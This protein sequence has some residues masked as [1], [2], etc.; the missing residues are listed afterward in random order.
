MTVTPTWL[1][2]FIDLPADQHT[3]GV[4]FWRAVTGY[5][6]S[7]PRGDDAEYAT[8][9]PADG[10]PYLRV[11]RLVDEGPA[12]VHL[13]LHDPEQEFQVLSSPAGLPYCHVYA[14]HEGRPRPATWPGGHQSIVDTVCI[15]IPPSRFEEEC[16]FWTERTG[17]PVVEFPTAPE[18]LGLRRPPGQ[19]IRILLQRLSD[20]QPQATAHLDLS[21]NGRAAE[22]RRHRDLGAVVV[23]EHEWWTVLR[24]PVGAEYCL[25]DRE[26]A[27]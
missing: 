5:G 24:D 13:D 10:D 8:L 26:L 23:R 7:A 22:M 25:V 6:L 19:P 20:E 1:T 9:L 18:F 4:A 16:A 21:T 27:D 2:A 3:E 14:A 12:R 15:D 11:Q 17:W